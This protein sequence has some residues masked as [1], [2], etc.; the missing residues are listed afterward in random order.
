MAIMVVNAGDGST[1]N[2]RNLNANQDRTVGQNPSSDW[3]NKYISSYNKPTSI[4]QADYFARIAAEKRNA[5]AIAEAQ[6]RAAEARRFQ[7][8]AFR[9]REAAMKNQGMQQNPQLSIFGAPL[10]GPLGGAV[11]AA[12]GFIAENPLG[13]LGNW[14]TS[15]APNFPITTD[16]T[17]KPLPGRQQTLEAQ[18]ISRERGPERPGYIQQP[19]MDSNGMI[20]GYKYIKLVQ[21]QIVTPEEATA[22][23][24]NMSMT[25]DQDRAR[26]EMGYISIYDEIAALENSY[27]KRRYD[28]AVRAWGEPTK[29]KNPDGSERIVWGTN[30]MEYLGMAPGQIASP[31]LQAP[32]EDAPYKD[33][34]KYRNRLK[35][36]QSIMDKKMYTD[37]SIME[38][39]YGMGTK[40][41]KEMQRAFLKAGLYDENDVVALGNVGEKEISFMRDLMTLANIN[42]TTWEEQFAMFQSAA[43]EQAARGGGGGGGGGTSVYT[44]IQYNQTSMAQGRALLISIL[45]DSLGRYPTDDEVAQ[46][47][48]MLNKAESKSPSKT[49]TRTTTGEGATRS[50]ARTTP[51]TVDPQALA[52]QFAQEIGGGK[53]YAAGKR[54][55]YLIGYLNSLGGTLG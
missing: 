39:Y 31:T 34:V 37:S 6:A 19:V 25:P 52:E 3:W 27:T 44:Q 26:R 35:S 22:A 53:P 7:E 2:P 17:G 55:Q 5:E 41:I 36:Q 30:G 50:V 20:T 47:I 14:L 48:D 11:E 45:K 46:F 18:G 13:K 43:K 28:A 42:G 54:D 40:G 29:E 1:Q 23:T 8:E 4:A 33:W 32:A 21:P 16:P 15:P 49:V 12:A 51:S 9:Q 38:T 10:S 24:Q